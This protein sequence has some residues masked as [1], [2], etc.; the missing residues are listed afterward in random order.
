MLVQSLPLWLSLGSS[1]AGSAA[2]CPAGWPAA[3]GV[4]LYPYQQ[5]YANFS[6]SG[7]RV[8]LPGLP[9]LRLG[10]RPAVFG[11]R[12][13]Q[14]RPLPFIPG[15]RP[16]A[17]GSLDRP[18]TSAP[19]AARHVQPMHGARNGLSGLSPTP[20]FQRSPASSTR[21]PPKATP[22]PLQTASPAAGQAGS[23]PSLGPRRSRRSL[24]QRR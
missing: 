18:P 5:A 19:L 1:S 20:V 4:C 15:F 16:L 17:V 24:H 13:G 21:P 7:V 6:V 2:V 12:P 11:P 3:H 23:C 8:I 22:P 14:A 9:S 10:S